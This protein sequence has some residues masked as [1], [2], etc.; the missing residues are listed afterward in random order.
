MSK[1]KIYRVTLKGGGQ[2]VFEADPNS[3][4]DII[5]HVKNLEVGDALCIAMDEMD[6]AEFEK[7][8]EF[9]GF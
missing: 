4:G 5:E 7:L 6:S 1:V 2:C 8:P 9:T 3:I